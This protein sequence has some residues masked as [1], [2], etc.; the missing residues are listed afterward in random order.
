M[1]QQVSASFKHN[2]TIAKSGRGGLRSLHAIWMRMEKKRIYH[3]VDETSW[4]WATWTNNNKM[5]TRYYEWREFGFQKR[6]S[7][8]WM[9][10]FRDMLQCICC[11][12]ILVL[13]DYIIKI[14]MY[15]INTGNWKSCSDIFGNIWLFEYIGNLAHEA[16]FM[17]IGLSLAIC[18]PYWPAYLHRRHM[19]NLHPNFTRIHIGTRWNS[20]QTDDFPIRGAQWL[21]LTVPAAKSV[22]DPKFKFYYSLVSSFRPGSTT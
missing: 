12:E 16:S 22:T 11:S 15:P 5:E 9:F 1:P 14:S 21:S 3:F 10:K 2:G 18:D 17:Q 7:V 20:S 4:K 13:G 8:L 6:A 19:E